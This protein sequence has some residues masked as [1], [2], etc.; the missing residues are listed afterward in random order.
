M[1]VCVFRWPEL[2]RSQSP[3]DPRVVPRN[4][5]SVCAS[6]LVP[7]LCLHVLLETNGR[8]CVEGSGRGEGSNELRVQK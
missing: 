7:E 2:L 8:L 5:L 6:S 4:Q 3:K 1:G